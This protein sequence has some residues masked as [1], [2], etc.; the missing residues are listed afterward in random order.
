MSH[1]RVP[2]ALLAAALLLPT[3]CGDDDGEQGEVAV[4]AYGESVIEEGIPAEEVGDGW[5]V[6]F[7]R[8]VV[9]VDS[10]VVGGAAV[11][12]ARSIDLAQGSGGAGHRLG[13]AAVAAGAHGDSSYVVERVEVQGAATR[14][15]ATKTFRW[16]FDSPTHYTACETTTTVPAGGEATFQIT[17]H[18]DHFLYDSLVSEDPQ[19]LFGAL[20]GADADGDG[21]ITRAEL[22]ATD[23]GGYD[24]GNE[25]ISNLWSWLVA[26]SRTLG[27]VDGEGHCEATAHAP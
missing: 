8:F 23:I 5:A 6:S 19:V 15:G 17:I 18:A 1:I 11:P 10:V 14:D 20:A 26:Q 7:E 3:A 4:T 25:D 9:T 12:V 27:H 21:V 13:S 16:V 22:E 24:P 2:C